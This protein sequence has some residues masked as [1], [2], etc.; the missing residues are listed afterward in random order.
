MSL[1]MKQR[2]PINVCSPHVRDRSLLRSSA[3]VFQSFETLRTHSLNQ[4]HLTD[5]KGLLSER[6]IVASSVSCWQSYFRKRDRPV[7]GAFPLCAHREA[8]TLNSTPLSSLF[9]S[10]LLVSSKSCL[11]TAGE[12]SKLASG[13]VVDERGSNHGNKSQCWDNGVFALVVV[14]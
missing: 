14:L 2:G 10:H 7:C 3:D 6:Q 5:R 12:K 13:D 4:L 9:R 1:P 11:I 8:R